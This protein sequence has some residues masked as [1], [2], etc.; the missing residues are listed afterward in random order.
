MANQIYGNPATINGE[1]LVKSGN[2]SLENMR[3]YA[4]FF[5]TETAQRR[6]A[7]LAAL[8]RP[9]PDRIFDR[10][11][12]SKDNPDKRLKWELQRIR[13]LQHPTISRRLRRNLKLRRIANFRALQQQ[14]PTRAP[15]RNMER[16]SR[17]VSRKC[18]TLA[19]E[20]V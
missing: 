6:Q 9:L 13:G 14:R 7:A 19:L 16:A 18:Y 8:H 20:F 11:G 17:K 12:P 1:R 3:N 2:R 4:N 5:R 15:P 10:I